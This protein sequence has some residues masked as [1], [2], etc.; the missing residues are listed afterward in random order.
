MK[1][2][3]RNLYYSSHTT[4]FSKGTIF[5]KKTKMYIFMKLQKRVYLLA[6]FDV[7]SMIL[8]SFRR[9]GNPHPP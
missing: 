8:T 2:E 1:T 3:L 5:A 7:S 9:G 6:L 4:V